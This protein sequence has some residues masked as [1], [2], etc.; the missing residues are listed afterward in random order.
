M[1]LWRQASQH[2]TSNHHWRSCVRN[3]VLYELLSL[4]GDAEEPGN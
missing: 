4:D 3:I 2:D 1:S